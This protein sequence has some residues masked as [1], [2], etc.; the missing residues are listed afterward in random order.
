MLHRVLLMGLVAG[1]LAGPVGGALAQDVSQT[2]A[3]PPDL[4]A[5]IK[6][7]EPDFAWK[8]VDTTESDAG[9][10]YKLHLVS[11]KWHNE[12]WEHDLVVTV[13]KGAKPSKTMVIY[14]TG[15]KPNTTT[16]LISVEIARRVQAPVAFLFGIPKQPLYDGKKEDALIAET[17][18]RF[19][20]TK[21][22]TWPLLFPMAKSLVK[23]MDALQELSKK[24]WKTEVT[25][26]IVTGA[27][28]RGWTSWLTAA[29][30][31]PRVKAIAPMVIDTLNFQKQIPL[32]VKSFGRY[33]EMIHDYEERNLLP[34]PDTDIGRRLWTMVDPWVYRDR[35]TL[36]KMLINGTNDPYWPQDALNQYWDDLKGEKFILYVPNAG[37]NLVEMPADGSKPAL[38]V[39]MRA[40]NTLAAFSRHIINEKPLPQLKWTHTNGGDKAVLV[41][42]SD[43]PAK[44]VRLWEASAKTRDFRKSRWEVAANTTGEVLKTGLSTELPK[45]G[46]KATFAEYEFEIDGLRYNMSTQIQIYDAKK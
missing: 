26:F 10:I 18:V 27:S 36:P 39:P 42:E 3:P 15:G 11:Q 38:P 5:Y 28:K 16:N 9:T 21:D 37:H 40:I 34:L 1:L 24:E 19:L 17:F 2:P 45:E 46:L 20:N 23:S 25:G 14:N 31:D 30:G 44:E 29:S 22:S 32:H 35:L 4:A 8:L 41:V 43:Q 13:P 12:L 6:K 7:P 33:S